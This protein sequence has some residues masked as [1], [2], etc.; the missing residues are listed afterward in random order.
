MNILIHWFY[1]RCKISVNEAISILWL[2][3]GSDV[4]FPALFQLQISNNFR[5]FNQSNFSIVQFIVCSD[6][7]NIISSRRQSVPPANFRMLIFLKENLLK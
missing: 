1:Q 2:F 6:G 7:G 5:K 3:L 4:I